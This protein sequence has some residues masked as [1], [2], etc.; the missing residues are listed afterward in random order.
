MRRSIIPLP[1]GTR[2]RKR[3]LK[4]SFDFFTLNR[5]NDNHINVIYT[6]ARYLRFIAMHKREGGPTH[7]TVLFKSGRSL[8]TGAHLVP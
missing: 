8:L 6:G 3:D 1:G 4:C 5:S 7:S 2:I